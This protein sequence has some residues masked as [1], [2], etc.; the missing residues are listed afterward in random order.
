MKKE[1]NSNIICQNKTLHYEYEVIET[2]TAGIVLQGTEVKSLRLH[3]ASLID[4]YCYIHD[5]ELY[6]KGLHIS[7]YEMGNIFN[8]DPDRVKKLLMTKKEI[9]KLSNRKSQD[10]YTIVPSKIMFINQ[11][12]KVELCVVKGK[13]LYDKR[14]DL[15]KSDQMRYIKKSI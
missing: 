8:H 12:V 5:N 4:A 2:Y 13:K 11:F 15:K 10:G 7:K 6:I 14:N 9:L 1:T 3:N